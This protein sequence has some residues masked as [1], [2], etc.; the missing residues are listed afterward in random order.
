MFRSKFLA[1]NLSPDYHHSTRTFGV[2]QNVISRN[3]LWEAIQPDLFAHIK[4]KN[5]YFW[6]SVITFE[7]FNGSGGLGTNLKQ[8]L[9][10]KDLSALFMI[11]FIIGIS[12]F[13]TTQAIKFIHHKFYFWKT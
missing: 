2:K 1:E 8:I 6:S 4:K 3:V 13:L 12:V 10:F 11:F 5:I 7:F 9:Q